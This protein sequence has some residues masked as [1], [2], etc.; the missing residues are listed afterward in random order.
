[1]GW[2]NV[3]AVSGLLYKYCLRS[4]GNIVPRRDIVLGKFG[5]F[6]TLELSLAVE[7]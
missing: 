1:M 3:G 2:D 7:V 4:I 6:P 5:T